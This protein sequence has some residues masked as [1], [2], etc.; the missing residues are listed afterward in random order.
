MSEDGA[1]QA[2]HQTICYRRPPLVIQNQKHDISNT[3]SC[4]PLPEG[5]LKPKVSQLKELSESLAQSPKGTR[6]REPK[7]LGE[8]FY[9]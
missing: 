4:T 8:L 5:Y 7:A 3:I 1:G 9:G 2:R 6:N